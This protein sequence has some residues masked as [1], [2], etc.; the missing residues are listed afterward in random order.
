[1][2]IRDGLL[3]SKLWFLSFPTKWNQSPERSGWTQVW[4]K[5]CRIWEIFS[6]LE[7]RTLSKTSGVVVKRTQKWANLTIK[8]NHSGLKHIKHVKHPLAHSNTYKLI[9]GH[10]WRTVGN[11]VIIP[12]TSN[13]K[14]R[15]QAFIQHFPVQIVPQKKLKSWWRKSPLQKHSS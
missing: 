3:T 12:Q 1:M 6:C 7:T 11:Q 5:K 2:L 13:I 4:A 14:R 8:N 9:I 15:K 10:L